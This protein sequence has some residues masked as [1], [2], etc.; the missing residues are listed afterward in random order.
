MNSINKIKSLIMLGT[1]HVVCKWETHAF[2]WIGGMA[3]DPGTNQDILRQRLGI[4]HKIRDMRF[5]N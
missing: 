3:K 5:T 1:K 2:G 4:I